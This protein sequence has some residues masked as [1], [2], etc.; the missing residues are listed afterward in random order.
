MILIDMLFLAISFMIAG[1]EFGEVIRKKKN[2]KSIIWGVIMFA[3]G[4]YFMLLLIGE[5]THLSIPAQ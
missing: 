4:L 1:N 3:W 5:S 2:W